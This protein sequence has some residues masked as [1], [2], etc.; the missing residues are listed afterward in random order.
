MNRT[1]VPTYIKLKFT[2]LIL[3][4]QFVTGDFD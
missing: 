3:K 1:M 4:L 2:F